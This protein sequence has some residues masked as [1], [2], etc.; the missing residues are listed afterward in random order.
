ME[1]ERVKKIQEKWRKVREL[2]RCADILRRLDKYLGEFLKENLLNSWIVDGF[3]K[4]MNQKEMK[5]ED[6]QAQ[7]SEV[8]ELCDE[9][10]GIVHNELESRSMRE[11]G[12][13]NELLNSGS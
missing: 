4:S 10:Y 6:Y 1:G 11:Y 7:L 2:E 9:I 12:K 8:E 13:R 3:W 5:R